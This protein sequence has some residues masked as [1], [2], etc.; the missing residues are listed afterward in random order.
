MTPAEFRAQVHAAGPFV[1]HPFTDDEQA[2]A[3][4]VARRGVRLS[5]RQ[6]QRMSD[7]E[8]VAPSAQG[9][10]RGGGA[11]TARHVV[12]GDTFP[13]AGGDARVDGTNPW[14]PSFVFLSWG[15]SLWTITEGTTDG[16]SLAFLASMNAAGLYAPW[17]TPPTTP[18]IAIR[19][20]DDG[21][22]DDVV[23]RDVSMVRLERLGDH[24]WWM[25]C[26]LDGEDYIEF[27]IDDDGCLHEVS[28]AD[29]GA[30][31]H[32]AREVVV[33]IVVHDDTWEDGSLA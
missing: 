3:A 10:D 1:G 29:P 6:G 2:A 8:A 18:R 31:R 15:R 22:V 16:I 12:V 13:H 9:P 32:T 25:R 27:N 7:P 19:P 28:I 4:A 11:M 24:L 17:Q 26:Y 5:G 33:P 23:I 21:S 14:R 20:D 30:H